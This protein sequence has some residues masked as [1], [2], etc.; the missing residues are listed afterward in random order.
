MDLGMIP[1][2]CL[3]FDFYRPFTLHVGL[4]RGAGFYLQNVST[5][6]EKSDQSHGPTQYSTL[7]TTDVSV[8]NLP[9]LN[10]DGSNSCCMCVT[11]VKNVVRS[12][13]ALLLNCAQRK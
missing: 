2:E 9:K 1:D 11:E 7:T 5:E 13:V 12:C 3:S 4:K 8:L 10:L 6:A